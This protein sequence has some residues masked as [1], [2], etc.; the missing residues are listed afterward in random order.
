MRGCK[1]IESVESVSGRDSSL[2][3]E[4]ERACEWCRADGRVVAVCGLFGALGTLNKT[5]HR[6]FLMQFPPH[7]LDITSRFRN[8]VRDS[9]VLCAQPLSPCRPSTRPPTAA[10]HLVAT[11]MPHANALRA[12]FARRAS[13]PALTRARL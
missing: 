4:S 11:A 6:P 9:P 1:S 10:A 3:R 12:A 5:L 13:P 7:S 2:Q 8:T